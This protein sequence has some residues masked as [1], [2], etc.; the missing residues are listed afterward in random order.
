MD[1][2]LHAF[3]FYA[4]AALYAHNGA[5]VNLNS[6]FK[7]CRNLPLA[8]ID[9]ANWVPLQ[10]EMRKDEKIQFL[11]SMLIC[12]Y[13]KRNFDG[14]AFRLLVPQDLNWLRWKFLHLNHTQDFFSD[15]TRCLKFLTWSQLFLALP[16]NM[17]QSIFVVGQVLNQDLGFNLY[18]KSNE[19]KCLVKD[20]WQSKW[21]FKM[22]MISICL[23]T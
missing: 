14:Q 1:N 9:H 22:A 4:A 20:I 17:L 13:H 18:P 12:W 10:L 19:Q 23:S 5:W 2:I 15:H 7:F 11:L 21:N 3:C 6:H 8:S 16:L